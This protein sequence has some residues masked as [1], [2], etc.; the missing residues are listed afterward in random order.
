M[1]KVTKNFELELNGEVF[2]LDSFDNETVSFVKEQV[3]IT[4]SSL[5]EFKRIFH[6][7]IKRIFAGLNERPKNPTLLVSYRRHLYKNPNINIDHFINAT[8]EDSNTISQIVEFIRKT[9]ADIKESN[10]RRQ[11]GE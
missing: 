7:E 3:N 4:F 6:S 8:Y 1:Q 5:D 11:M 9:E 10:I 2:N